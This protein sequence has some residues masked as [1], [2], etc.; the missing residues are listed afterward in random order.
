M[1]GVDGGVGGGNPGDAGCRLR[2]VGYGRVGGFGGFG[3]EQRVG[4]TWLRLG[5]VADVGALMGRE[6]GVL[7][8]FGGHHVEHAAA[9]GGLGEPHTFGASFEA[10]FEVSDAPADLSEGVAAA[11]E[12]HNDVVVDLCDRGAVA[13]VAVC[14]GD[15]GV[16]DAAIGAGSLVGEPLEQSGAEVEAHAGVV[17]DDADDLVFEVGDAGGAVGGVTLG[18]DAVVPVVV[19]GSRVLHFDGFQPGIL[20]RRLVE[21]AMHADVAVGGRGDGLCGFWG[22]TLNHGRI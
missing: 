3:G 6:D 22:G 15:V 13:A 1:G 16:E 8:A 17:V 11:G 5:D 21:V 20:A 18:G 19:R 4:C 9:D 14:A 2:V 10:V 7:D 12:R